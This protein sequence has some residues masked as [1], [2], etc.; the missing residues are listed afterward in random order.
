MWQ[1]S[2]LEYEKDPL[3]VA[4]HPVNITQTSVT[5][6]IARVVRDMRMYSVNSTDIVISSEVF[7]CWIVQLQSLYN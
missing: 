3:A 6:V 7:E 4:M 2:H 5:G 1:S